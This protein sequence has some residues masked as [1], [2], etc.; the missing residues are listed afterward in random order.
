MIFALLICL[1]ASAPLKSDVAPDRPKVKIGD[2]SHVG[3][4]FGPYG[5]TFT[6][7][8]SPGVR[9]RSVSISPDDIMEVVCGGDQWNLFVVIISR[10]GYDR[11]YRP[12]L[13]GEKY[14]DISRAAWYSAEN[15]YRLWLRD[16]AQRRAADARREAER[17]AKIDRLRKT[18][19]RP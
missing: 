8:A 4:A 10:T 16:A 6:A 7:P 11:I 15:Q 14:F 13:Y 9:P 18:E 3:Y 19:R 17:R 12:D 2:V 5:V 1:L